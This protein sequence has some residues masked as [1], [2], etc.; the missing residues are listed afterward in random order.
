M[1]TLTFKP[2]SQLNKDVLTKFKYLTFDQHT[3]YS[4]SEYDKKY[5]IEKFNRLLPYFKNFNLQIVFKVYD[6][7]VNNIDVVILKDD[8]IFSIVS[9]KKKNSIQPHYYYQQLFDGKFNHDNTPKYI[10]EGKFTDKKI[11]E[12]IDFS[13]QQINNIINQN[14]LNNNTYSQVQKDTEVLLNRLNPYIQYNH[15]NNCKIY[16][17]GGLITIYFDRNLKAKSVNEQFKTKVYEYTNVDKLL[18]LLK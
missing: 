3:N 7:H 5:A 1:E 18:D 6:N 15:S 8:Y 9:Y 17:I 12:W 14:N 4:F 13:I 11:N 16:Y 2:L 10:G